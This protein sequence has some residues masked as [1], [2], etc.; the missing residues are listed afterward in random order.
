M[1]RLNHGIHVRLQFGWYNDGLLRL[2]KWRT[3]LVHSCHGI[4]VRGSVAII[5][6][7]LLLNAVMLIWRSII[8]QNVIEIPASY[9]RIGIR[10]QLHVHDAQH[11]YIELNGRQRIA[12]ESTTLCGRFDH[13]VRIAVEVDPVPSFLFT[14][15]PPHP[16]HPHK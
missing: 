1:V 9:H 6:T 8:F 2:I 5:P 3:R 15:S 4:V 16:S 14:S 11:R 7:V 12:V 13:A 10:I